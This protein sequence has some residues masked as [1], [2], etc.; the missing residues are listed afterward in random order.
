M[1]R[2]ACILLTLLAGA[3]GTESDGDASLDPQ[4]SEPVDGYVDV[5]GINLHYRD[6]GG[7]GDL[8][9]LVPSLSQTA[10][11]YDLLAPHLTHRYHVLAVTKR[12]HGTSDTTA[13]DFDLDTLA[14]DLAGFIEHVA[15]APAIVVGWSSAGLEMPALARRRPDLVRALIFA[16]A[17]YAPMPPPPPELWPPGQVAPDSV[18]PSLGA[19]ADHLRHMAGI[20][21]D[22]MIA[23]LGNA[24]VERE[25]GMF[26]WGRPI[27]SPAVLGAFMALGS[28]WTADFYE[29]IDVPVLAIRVQQSHALAAELRAR[30]FP[31]DSIDVALRFAREYDDVSKTRGIER[32]LA[33]VPH[34]EVV[35]L[36][37]VSHNFVMDAPAVAARV[38]DEFL[39]RLEAADDATTHEEATRTSPPEDSFVEVDGVRLHYRDYGG[40]GDVLLFVPSLFTTAGVYDRTPRS[41]C[42]MTCRTTS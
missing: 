26:V 22:E 12:W 16:N 31:Q 21:R 4:P 41:S 27:S 5:G 37:S 35:V 40:E 8:M 24:L 14:D 38:M 30:G 2:T 17:V 42:W 18:Y 1:K 39:R 25:D 3:C 11:V 6:Y 29:G 19:A 32:L 10:H 34:A 20:P 9:V 36:D 33:S 13:L 7:T 15:D 23:F 28:R